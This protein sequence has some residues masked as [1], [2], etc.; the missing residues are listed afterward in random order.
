MGHAARGPLR[1]GVQLTRRVVILG[2]AGPSNRWANDLEDDIELWAMNMCHRFLTRPAQRWFQMHH[3]MHNR[4]SGHPPGHFGR[5][6]DHEEY[7]AALEI[8][9]YMQRVDPLI[10]YSVEY[11]LTEVSGAFGGYFTSTV[12]YMLALALYEGVDEIGLLGIYMN[13]GE[14]Y[15]EQRSCVEYYLGIAKAARVNIVLPTDSTLTKAPLYAYDEFMEPRETL[16]LSKV[17]VLSV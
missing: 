15:R 11:P 10:P 1:R 17:E 5:P 13:N 4:E 3:R 7:L 16:Q 14:E 2:A 12:A 8:P 9:V 6:L